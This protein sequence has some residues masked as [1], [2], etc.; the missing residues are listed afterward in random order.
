MNLER[1]PSHRAGALRGVPASSA[2]SEERPPS[3]LDKRRV[4]P[5]VVVLGIVFTVGAHVLIPL[6]VMASQWLL[7][8]LG[9]AIP[10][11]ER[12]RPLMPD[13]VIAAEFVKLGKP[14]DPKKLPNRKVPPVAK[15]T[16][17]GVAVSKDAREVEQKKPEEKKER[18]PDTKDSLLDNLV[19]RTKDF[20]EDVEY[21]EE[22]DPNGLREGTATEAREGDLYRG[23]LL[24]FFQRPWTV[25]NIVQDLAKKKTTVMVEVA[26][27]GRLRSVELAKSSGDPLYDQSALDA[28]TALIQSGAV[29]PEPPPTL[30]D[31]FY[32]ATIAVNYD[33]R[34]AR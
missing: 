28:V 4:E 11:E 32:G 6:L 22:G 8:F 24:L 31:Q 7:V 20:A 17:D 21:E 5:G 25:P 9:L 3:L 23:Q 33:G 19:D 26:R 14:L 30:R 10:V 2:G 27:D 13:N 15:R 16:P 34:N 12:Q 18:P 1:E 29:L